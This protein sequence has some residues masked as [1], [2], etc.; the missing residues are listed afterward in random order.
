MDDPKNS[1]KKADFSRAAANFQIPNIISSIGAKF[2]AGDGDGS[3]GRS[4]FWK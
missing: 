2:T 1:S 3:N 4:V